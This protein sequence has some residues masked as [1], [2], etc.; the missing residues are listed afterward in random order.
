MSH[1]AGACP[2]PPRQRDRADE[3]VLRLDQPERLP[4]RTLPLQPPARVG[5]GL[6][7]GNASQP[8]DVRILLQMPEGM[9]MVWTEGRGAKAAG[10][11]VLHADLA[12]A[13]PAPCHQAG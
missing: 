2:L 6:E 9:A 10:F 3:T 12:F 8:D 4:P 7:T 1:V 13:C 11:E 5:G